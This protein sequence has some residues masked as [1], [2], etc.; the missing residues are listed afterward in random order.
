MTKLP[1]LIRYP[2]YTIPMVS[3][4]T[5]SWLFDK[6]YCPAYQQLNPTGAFF[7]VDKAR[8]I[9]WTS[10]ILMCNRNRLFYCASSERVSKLLRLDWVCRGRLVRCSACP[11]KLCPSCPIPIVSISRVSLSH[12]I[13]LHCWSRIM[14]VNTY[15]FQSN[16]DEVRCPTKIL[17]ITFVLAV[18]K[19][20]HLFTRI[21]QYA[22][23]PIKMILVAWDMIM[24]FKDIHQ[25][26]EW[27]VMAKWPTCPVAKLVL[28]SLNFLQ[29][30]PFEQTPLCDLNLWLSFD[31]S[32]SWNLHLLNCLV[33][34]AFVLKFIHE[35]LILHLLG[36]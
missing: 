26:K 18:Y 34:C 22:W 19:I 6:S 31:A 8:G 29:N 28:V 11:I 25:N 16:L 15:K 36:N 32:L 35:Y 21:T 33:Q 17:K 5:W 12:M 23:F 4:L 20:T 27:R 30:V 1:R 2:S 9:M 24:T 14:S 13:S 3:W 10:Y 7:C